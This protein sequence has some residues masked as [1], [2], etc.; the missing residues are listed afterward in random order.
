MSWLE[1]DPYLVGVRTSDAPMALFSAVL[2][3]LVFGYGCHEGWWPACLASSLN[4]KD[5]AL[6][7]LLVATLFLLP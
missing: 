1:S 6:V 3:L 5:Q 2:V 4:W 7:E